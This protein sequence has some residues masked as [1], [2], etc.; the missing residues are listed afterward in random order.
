MAGRWGA[1]S[2]VDVTEKPDALELVGSTSINKAA[3]VASGVSDTW[4]TWRLPRNADGTLKGTFE[5]KGE[6]M[7][8]E[9]DV[10]Y[11]ADLGGSGTFAPDQ[12]H[13][14]TRMRTFSQLAPEGKILPWDL[15]QLELAEP[16]DRAAAVKA[17]QIVGANGATLAVAWDDSGAHVTDWA[18][19]SSISGH[20]TSWPNATTWSGNVGVVNDRV[21]LGSAA[22]SS[23]IEL[24][25]LG[26]K[27]TDVEFDDDIVY[28]TFWGATSLLGG[29]FS[30]GHDPHCEAG[31]CL[32]L[33]SPPVNSCDASTRVGMATRLARG[34]TGKVSVRYRVLA[35]PTMASPSGPNVPAL[36]TMQVATEGG[37]VKEN[38][39]PAGT[40][41][42]GSV[43]FVK[44]ST[45][46]D[47]F[48][49]ATPWSTFEMDA[50]PGAGD[51]GVAIGTRGS[52]YCGGPPYPEADITVLI[53]NVKSL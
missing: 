51:L 1:V 39:L 10:M 27:T 29:G 47:Q 32:R 22:S 28:P 13:P 19:V 35:H 37:A 23:P 49:W 14:E 17:S 24:I 8:G 36:T 34:A 45:P 44:L 31:G 40:S 9:G 42:P 33:D 20:A 3:S 5:A 38:V 6:E 26:M 48:E 18:G 50:P 46:I 2:S 52:P 43:A 4:K 25:T 16:I 41:Y 53:E 30:G 7:F 21:D 12:T 15:I 11:Q